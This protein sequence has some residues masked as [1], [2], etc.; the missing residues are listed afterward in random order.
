V[1]V[2][3]RD[4]F[5]PRYRPRPV[6]GTDIVVYARLNGPWRKLFDLKLL[7]K[8]RGAAISLLPRAP[9]SAI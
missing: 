6:V 1:F 7:C 8:H 5:Q 2:G 9:V 3:H 4:Y